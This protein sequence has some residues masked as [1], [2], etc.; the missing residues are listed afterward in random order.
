MKHNDK[1][2]SRRRYLGVDVGGTKVLASVVAENG[3]I[4]ARERQPT[5]RTGGPEQVLAV[6]EKTIEVVLA[7]SKFHREHLTAIGIAVPGV[8]DTENSRVVVTPNMNLSGVSLGAHLESHF[9]VPVALGND[10]NLG[11]L[12]DKWLGSARNASSAVAILVGT[13]IGGGFV[14]RGKLW[15]G[16]RDAAAEVGHMVIQ[17]DGPLCGCGNRGCLEA[18]ASRTAIERDIRAAVAAGRK[19]VLSELC[20]G[21][22]SVIRSNVIRKALEAEDALTVEIMRRAAEILG[23]ACLTVRHLVDPEVIVLGGGVIEACSDFMLPIVENIVGSDRLPGA[24]DCGQVLLSALGDDAVVLGAVALA[25]QLVGRNPFKRK[26]AVPPRY[27]EIAHAG[28]GEITVGDENFSHDVYISVYGKVKKRKKSIARELYNDAHVVGAKELEV[29]C[30]GGPEL[31]IV[32]AGKDAKLELTDDARRFLEQRSIK[33]QILPT[34]QAVEAYNSASQRKA[35][36]I[37]VT[38]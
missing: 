37:H 33:Y 27:P 36:L 19:T 30:Q 9:K 32:G 31:L 7:K 14:R 6:I 3:E 5:P 22:L 17:L 18:L 11:A 21:D 20:N 25:R 10:C 15:R 29:V 38:C 4:L 12:G 26:Y 34:P 2:G 23:Y 28:F 35:T 1:T 24:R 8:V 13:G 16:A